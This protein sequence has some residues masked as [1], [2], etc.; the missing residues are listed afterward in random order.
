MSLVGRVEDLEQQQ[1]KSDKYIATLEK[2]AQEYTNRLV[3]LALKSNTETLDATR[4]L[5]NTDCVLQYLDPGG[6]ARTVL[7]PPEAERNHLFIIVN[8][9]DAAEILTVKEDSDTT[10]ILPLGESCSGI[11]VCNGTS[12]KGLIQTEDSLGFDA[13]VDPDANRMIVWDDSQSKLRWFNASTGLEIYDNGNN[14]A[15]ITKDSEIV[16]DS[17]SGF[18]ANEHIDH[19]SV[20]ITTGTGITGGGD[21]S[22]N[23]TFDVD[24]GITDNKVMQVDDADA[25]S[26]DYAK[27]TASGLQ[28][29]DATEVRSDINVEDGST[30]DQTGAEIKTAYETEADTNAYDDAAV[31]KLAGIEV[32]A[33]ITD[34]TNV[35]AAGAVM[36]TLADAANDFLVASGNDAIVKKTLAET[37]AILEADIDHGNIQGLDTGADHSYIDQD[38]TS[39][40]T[41]LFA[42]LF[43]SGGNFAVHTGPAQHFHV[44]N[45]AK[46]VSVSSASDLVVYSGNLVTEVARIDGATGNITTSGTVDGIDIATDVAA[47]TTHRGSDGS[48]HSGLIL[49]SLA[50]A[51]NDF[52]VASGANAYVK[53]TLAETGAI[54]EADLDHGN[55]QGLA[56]DDHSQ[57]ALLAGRDA[58]TLIIDQVRAYDGAGLKLYEDGGK[59]VFIEDSTG[60]AG[61]LTATPQAPVHVQ[62]IASSFG[63]TPNA[64]TVAIFER[65]ADVVIDLV[66]GDG[67]TGEI[68]FGD[69]SADI[70]GRLRF[71]HSDNTMQIWGGGS[72]KISFA[73]G[74]GIKLL[75]Q[76]A[77]VGDTTAFGQLWV[78]TATPN[79]LMFTDD[80]GTDFTVDVTPV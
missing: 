39:S 74:G 14:I 52:L 30:A 31:T 5:L 45:A 59:G 3:P 80:A 26:G 33:D 50:D 55:I 37:G 17:L 19:T 71:D 47:N 56:G 28:G 9:A 64:R 10:T 78:K 62:A 57:Y 76:A 27:F 79:V 25:A 77:A 23:R 53:K 73:A 7:L 67:G 72:K 16:H 15:L 49:H 68:W 32:T 24:V 35:A 75:E 61:F 12:W 63:W 66:S 65:A 51:A 18:V 44:N 38:V 8:T 58:N 11:F 69:T 60:H 40:G 13:L 48:D 6:A 4:V 1:A 42:S 36:A 54:L 43:V 41:P 70:V 22:A 29:R 21:I 20:T 2:T 34:A 46:I